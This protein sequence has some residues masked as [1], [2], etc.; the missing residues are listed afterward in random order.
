AVDHGHRQ[1]LPLGQLLVD[2]LLGPVVRGQ[3]DLPEAVAVLD[4]DAAVDVG[5]GRLA[6]RDASLEELGHAGQTGRDVVAG[7]TT[8]VEGAHRQLRAG[9]TDGL[10]GHD[11]HGLADVH[12]LAGGHRAA[13]AHAADAGG[14]LAGQGA[15]HLDL[16]D[17][18]GDQR[19]ERRVA[20]VAAL[21][22]DHLAVR[23]AHLLRGAARVDA[24]A[25]EAVRDEPAVGRLLGD[26]HRDA[27]LGAAVD[28]ADDDVL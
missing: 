18:R 17:A 22:D 8:G 25:D 19:V 21:G 16:P 20:Q 3:G 5:D 15:A 13:V 27:A 2:D 26:L 1:P 14:G 23:A 12:Q 24:G 10:R 9:L 6:L 4:G 7:H 28:L 11:A